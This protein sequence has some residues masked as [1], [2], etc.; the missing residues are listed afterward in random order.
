MEFDNSLS[1]LLVDDTLHT[2]EEFD[3]HVKPAS[4]SDISINT[5][6]MVRQPLT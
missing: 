5:V 4:D 3:E 6:I 2:Q 1:E